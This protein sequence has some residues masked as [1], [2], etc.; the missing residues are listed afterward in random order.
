MFL[1]LLDAVVD[2]PGG[3]DL[4]NVPEWL[5]RQIQEALDPL[6]P[7]DGTPASNFDILSRVQMVEATF[8][9]AIKS[10]ID[11][12]A[13][14]RLVPSANLAFGDLYST[15]FSGE[16][17]A[18]PRSLERAAVVVLCRGLLFFQYHLATLLGPAIP[19]DVCDELL[20]GF[21]HRGGI[22]TSPRIVEVRRR[23][24]TELRA[25]FLKDLPRE[26]SYLGKNYVELGILH[27][28]EQNRQFD[29]LPPVTDRERCAHPLE[30]GADLARFAEDF[31][32]MHEI[33]HLNLGH[34]WGDGSQDAHTREFE[35]DSWAIRTM[36]S[37][38]DGR[39]H[40][41]ILCGATFFLTIAG[42][43][44]RRTG[45]DQIATHPSASDR[46]EAVLAAVGGPR[47]AIARR[48]S[49]AIEKAFATPP[50]D[51]AMSMN[52]LQIGLRAAFNPESLRRFKNTFPRWLAFGAPAKLCL[53]LAHERV[54][55][56]GELADEPRAFETKG[57]ME[58]AL[59]AYEITEAVS[60]PVLSNMLAALYRKAKEKL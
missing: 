28:P 51:D 21:D 3:S 50:V 2:D 43:L 38:R 8:S 58:A 40:I 59:W 53:A 5:R 13:Q 25:R 39:E 16:V 36:L 23:T 4:R 54:R 29:P 22:M 52:S 56:E 20:A 30:L 11:L 48:M 32:C 33:A 35:A 26:L 46:L 18:A 6:L 12:P 27:L 14:A 47:A 7:G 57:A 55:I 45:S 37:A 41:A 60:N 10:Y 15:D 24:R 42:W 9:F 44:E 19:D 49:S 1:Q 34:P 17:I 31:I